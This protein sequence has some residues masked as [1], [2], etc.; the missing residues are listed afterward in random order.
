MISPLR[1]RNS[2]NKRQAI[3]ARFPRALGMKRT[4]DRLDDYDEAENDPVAGGGT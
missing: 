2:G 3:P 4:D 1:T